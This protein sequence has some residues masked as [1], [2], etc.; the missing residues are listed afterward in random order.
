MSVS[1]AEREVIGLTNAEAEEDLDQEVVDDPEA[2][3][4]ATNPDQDLAAEEEA[5]ADQEADHLQLEVV[6]EEEKSLEAVS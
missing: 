6:E 3:K 1:I 2:T 4:D 5:V